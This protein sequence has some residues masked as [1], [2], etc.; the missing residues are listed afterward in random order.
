MFGFRQLSGCVFAHP[1]KVLTLGL[2]LGVTLLP[3]LGSIVWSMYDSLS[4]I[5]NQELH[6]QRLIGSVAHLNEVLTMYAR[7]AA[8]TGDPKWEKQYRALEPELDNAILGVAMQAH[9]EYEKTY[10]AQTKLSYT[11]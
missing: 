9:E 6:L 1:M 5:G 2:I 3:I 10:V 7:L 4:K 11:K 8:A